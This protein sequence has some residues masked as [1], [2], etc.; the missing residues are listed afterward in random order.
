MSA[1]LA[2]NIN[3]VVPYNNQIDPL[4]NSLI[5]QDDAQKKASADLQAQSAADAD[6]SGTQVTA[7]AQTRAATLQES[8]DSAGAQRTGNDADTLSGSSPLATKKKSASRD[9]KVA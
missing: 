8:A 3:K 6:T 1:Q 9:L 5:A 4:G 2:R 7:N